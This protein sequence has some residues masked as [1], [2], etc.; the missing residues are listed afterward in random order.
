MSCIDH[1]AKGTPTGY[2][3][4]KIGG[5]NEYVHRYTLA[6]KLGISLAGIGSRVARH[7]CDNPRCINPDHLVLGTQRDNLQDQ[8]D[9]GRNQKLPRLFTDE[10]KIAIR[11]R[12]EPKDAHNGMAAMSREFRSSTATM[13]RIVHGA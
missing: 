2:L 9:R 7:T 12:Y 11:L 8:V 13:H 1:G 10:Q 4:R 6:V 5:R 3:R